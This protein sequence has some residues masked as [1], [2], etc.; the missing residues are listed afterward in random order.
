MV[1]S[2]RC[3]WPLLILLSNIVNT[4]KFRRA[5]IYVK[6]LVTDVVIVILGIWGLSVHLITW[7]IVTLFSEESW[8]ENHFATLNGWYL[9]PVAVL[10]SSILGLSSLVGSLL[11]IFNSKRIGNIYRIEIRRINN[12]LIDLNTRS[13]KKVGICKERFLLS[14]LSLLSSVIRLLQKHG[15]IWSHIWYDID[16]GWLI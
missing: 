6:W 8:R 14:F 7:F 4:W 13:L 3:F 16:K 15:F 5:V 11:L 1:Y 12:G 2:G 9:Y 10:S